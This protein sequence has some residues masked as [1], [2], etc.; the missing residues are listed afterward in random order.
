MY[1]YI[2]ITYVISKYALYSYF[3]TEKIK[4]KIKIPKGNTNSTGR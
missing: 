2:H 4:I 3:S 1:V